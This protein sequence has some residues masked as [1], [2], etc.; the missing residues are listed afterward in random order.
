MKRRRGLRPL[1][2]A[3]QTAA[4]GTEVVVHH[5]VLAVA[6]L[7]AR[8]GSSQK[9]TAMSQVPPSRHPASRRTQPHPS[10]SQAGSDWGREPLRLTERSAAWSMA[11]GLPSIA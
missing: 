5:Q 11:E 6:A 7:H 8:P 3:D 9:T 10:P 1:A 2:E 4:A